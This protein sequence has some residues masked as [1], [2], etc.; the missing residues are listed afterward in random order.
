MP[1]TSL[2]LKSLKALQGEPPKTQIALVRIAWPEIK[3]ALAQGHS[4]R[5]VHQRLLEAHVPIKYRLLS[6]YVCRLRR[7]EQ[8]PDQIAPV[9]G[10]K[11][12]T[13]VSGPTKPIRTTLVHTSTPVDANQPDPN[14]PLAD[15]E[16]RI[17]KANRFNFTPGLPDES[18]LI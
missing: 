7:E 17:G 12:A 5:V 3:L 18:K 13:T 11:I 1:V 15:F 10:A 6:Q 9:C 2:D 16:K 14:H 8:S 4:L